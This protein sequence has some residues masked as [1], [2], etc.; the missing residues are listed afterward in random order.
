MGHLVL[1]EGG[2]TLYYNGARFAPDRR[3]RVMLT[4][5]EARDVELDYEQLGRVVFVLE[6]IL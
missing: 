5:R 2:I 3:S 6:V 1:N 4:K